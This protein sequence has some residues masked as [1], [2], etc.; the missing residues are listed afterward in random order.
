MKNPTV[1]AQL[2][3]AKDVEQKWDENQET[4][5]GWIVESALFGRTDKTECFEPLSSRKDSECNAVW[6]MFEWN[7]K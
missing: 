3:G 6:G 7:G 1:Q 2:K 5:R 4:I